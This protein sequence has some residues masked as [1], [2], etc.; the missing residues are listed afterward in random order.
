MSKSK[1]PASHLITSDP[2]SFRLSWWGC[3]PCQRVLLQ[4]C[5]NKS[6]HLQSQL[7]LESSSHPKTVCSSCP[8]TQN[9][10][11]A[12][13]AC[14]QPHSASVPLPS[15]FSCPSR[16]TEKHHPP[17]NEGWHSSLPPNAFP[18]HKFSAPQMPSGWFALTMPHTAVEKNSSL[19]S[20]SL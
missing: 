4:H 11:V 2:S 15:S 20:G 8:L 18:K 6:E 9:M 12:L 17:G 19:G 7:S 10:L 5:A 13:Y 14:T 1:L 3:F 16:G